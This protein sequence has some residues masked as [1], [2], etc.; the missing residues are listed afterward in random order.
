[1]NK[2]VLALYDFASKQEFIYR[3]SKIKEISG[4]STLL[5]EIYAKFPLILNPQVA[6]NY[7]L[8][9]PFS[10]D[11]FDAGA[12]DGEVLYD[13]G[14]NLLVLWKSCEVYLKANQIISAYLLKNVP[15]LTMIACSVPYTGLFDDETDTE[16]NIRKKGDRTLLYERN[17]LRKNRYPAFD[18][19]SVTPFTQIDPITFLPVVYKRNKNAPGSVYPA[20]DCSLS[21]DRYAKAAK[22]KPEN[23][24][25]DANEGLLA[26][27]YI[28]GNA[29][30]AKLIACRS[31]DYN[32][33]V[34]KLRDFSK[35]VN[36]YYVE[37]PIQRIREAKFPFRKVIGGGD[38]IT[39]IC[40]GEDAFRIMQ[41]Y[42]SVLAEH[43]IVLSDY[44]SI[45]CTSCAGIAIFHA[46]SPF[47]IAY[48]LAEAACESAKKK[49]HINGGNYFSFYYA[50]GGVTDTF[51]RLHLKEQAH[52]SG[53]HY[54]LSDIGEMKAYAVKLFSTG[55]SNVKALGDAAQRGHV[56]YEYETRRVNAYL[57]DLS[58][59]NGTEEE[60]R[61]V[62]DMSEFY[63]L[64]FEREG[65]R[66]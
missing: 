18:M 19:P 24:L 16:G 23:D 51:E 55:R 38:E 21:A 15:G 25:E 64:W 47:D 63:D 58:A 59:F 49:A 9:V 62:Y 31:Q 46:K 37:Y 66:R 10:V 43:R 35:Q 17:M 11:L 30:G 40:R 2:N 32:E 29:M 44:S 14:G 60:M 13:G 53:K 45:E 42:F 34:A 52:V 6:L 8:T 12:A 3:T 28:D 33:G 56:F 7:D 20:F 1:M 5:S 48:G 22:Y 36:D 65:K 61:L 50:H 39:L 41:L 57:G 4:A 27:I 54:G 26:V